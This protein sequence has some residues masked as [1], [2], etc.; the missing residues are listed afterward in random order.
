MRQRRA[1]SRA[2]RISGNELRKDWQPP[3]KIQNAEQ[4]AVSKELDHETQL[5][6]Q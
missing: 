3:E 2:P 4:I 5:V 1:N 6:T